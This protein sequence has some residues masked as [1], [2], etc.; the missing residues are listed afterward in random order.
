MSDQPDASREVHDLATVCRHIKQVIAA[1]YA[2]AIWVK[3]EIA[4]VGRSKVGAYITLVDKDQSESINAQLD[5]VIW[6]STFVKIRAKVGAELLESLLQKG[7]EV[8]LQIQLSFHERYG[9]KA[10]IQD[11]DPSFSLGQLERIRMQNYEALVKSGLIHL[12]KT[13]PLALVPRQL[14]IISSA[15]AAGLKDLLVQLRD[16]PYGYT[17]KAKFF[18]AAVQGD[19][20]ANE[21]IRALEQVQYAKQHFDAIVLVR[22]GG[23]KLDLAAFDHL[24][25]C[26]SIANCP[27]PVI[28]GIGHEID[29]SLADEVAHTALKTPTAVAAFLI[30]HIA[31]A[32]GNTEQLFA[33]IV[34]LGKRNIELAN[35]KLIVLEEQVQRESKRYIQ[36]QQQKL[37]F[38]AERIKIL[39]PAAILKRGYA[40][41]YKQGQLISSVHDSQDQDQLD[42]QFADGMIRVVR[43]RR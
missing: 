29:R 6:Q 39:D 15:K 30:N 14:A 16:N 38:V 4:Q 43:G 37:E 22:G 34:S 41:V 19:G 21:I 3:A 28:T 2:K 25:L 32:E 5:A 31:E 24:E 8:M 18:N 40:L 20:A 13:K 26:K 7:Q 23:S 33:Q 12:N 10:E 35:R 36:Q 1:N 27:I 42:I 9:L 17:F 11:V